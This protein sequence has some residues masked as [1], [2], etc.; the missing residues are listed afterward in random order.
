MHF[1]D[2]LLYR[3]LD[4]DWTK[5]EN[6]DYA[7]TAVNG[8]IN[9]SSPFHTQASASEDISS[10]IK[11]KDY[12]PEQGWVLL[13]KEFGSP[14]QP[15]ASQYPY[16]ILYN[17][18]RGIVRLFLMNSNEFQHKNALVTLSWLSDDKTSLLTNH[19]IYSFA[20]DKYNSDASPT[21]KGLNYVQDCYAWLVSDFVVTFDNNTDPNNEKNYLLKFEIFFDIQADIEVSGLANKSS[22]IAGMEI[23][24]DVKI[25]ELYG[26]LK[27]GKRFMTK[28]LSVSDFKQNLDEIDKS[29]E[30][31][32]WKSA[33]ELSEKL[34]KAG[35]S[36]QD[37]DIKKFMLGNGNLPLAMN[38]G[39]DAILN[40]SDIFI[41]KSNS[42]AKASAQ[43][44]PIIS[45]AT[46]D[47]TGTMT[48]SSNTASCLLQL[49]G[50]NHKHPDG[51]PIEAGM[52]LYD[53][54]LG[55]VGLEKTPVL[56]KRKIQNKLRFSTPHDGYH[57]EIINIGNSYRISDDINIVV[58]PAAKVRLI[59]AKVQLI[60]RVGVSNGKP[61]YKIANTPIM[62]CLNKGT[63]V[64]IEKNKDGF[65]KFG[66]PLTDID[67]FQ[68]TAFMVKDNTDLY[69]KVVAI[70]ESTE[71][72]ADKTPIIISNTYVLDNFKEIHHEKG[73][74]TEDMYT[75]ENNM[76]FSLQLYPNPASNILN[77]FIGN[78]KEEISNIVIY[79]RY[80]KSLI[81][82][83][84]SGIY[85]SLDISS[86]KDGVYLFEVSNGKEL[87]RKIF[88]K[89]L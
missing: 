78:S 34:K 9:I 17:K 64:L 54:P 65:D 24:K 41:N 72:T 86:L 20:N 84:I 13:A 82:K 55:V 23:D 68:N 27:N 10:I 19:N 6:Y 16:F 44:Q 42:K 73:Y 88:I 48:T 40:V 71:P 59:D 21:D 8:K 2:C 60:G 76:N 50:T 7:Y 46:F 77:I 69:L 83:T 57:T 36:L 12:L 11:A 75:S 39:L 66:T 81:N 38:G 49:P 1:C 22:S 4:W 61:A 32:N 30:N 63:Y 87:I 15:I 18:F 85:H 62:S 58:N 56:E 79:N 51:T 53:F 31:L 89:K 26:G 33:Q 3:R 47:I 74:S 43:M 67:K 35:Q 80:G 70:L 29:I 14:A 5:A 25:N 37:G 52:P 28:V 45:N